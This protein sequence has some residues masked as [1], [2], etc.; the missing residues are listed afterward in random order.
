M[1]NQAFRS[2]RAENAPEAIQRYS[3][4]AKAERRRDMQ[5]VFVRLGRCEYPCKPSPCRSSHGCRPSDMQLIP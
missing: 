5:R 1:R 4:H 3:G 2:T